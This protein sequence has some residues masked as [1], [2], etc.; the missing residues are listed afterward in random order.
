MDVYDFAISQFT[1][2]TDDKYFIL[3]F[4][5]VKIDW[6]SRDYIVLICP[7]NKLTCLKR[8]SSAKKQDKSSNYNLLERKMSNLVIDAKFVQIDLQLTEL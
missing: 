5:T 1:T 8:H 4:P 6:N 2:F 7:K 3:L